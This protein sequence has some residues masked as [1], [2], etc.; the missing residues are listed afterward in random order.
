[1]SVV[2]FRLA[3]GRTIISTNLKYVFVRNSIL[4]FLSSFGCFHRQWLVYTVWPSSINI[5]IVTLCLLSPTQHTQTVQC[6]TMH[7]NFPIQIIIVP[8]WFHLTYSII[9]AMNGTW[10]GNIPMEDKAVWCMVMFFFG[11]FQCLF[12]SIGAD[13]ISCF[14]TLIFT[15][16]LYKVLVWINQFRCRFKIL[17]NICL[18]S[19]ETHRTHRN[20]MYVCVLSQL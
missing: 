1:M 9:T 11:L 12:M 15:P 13:A 3:G 16:K 10:I 8:K 5:L 20:C 19:F 17:T 4:F 6:W 2:Y 7:G 14:N 18:N